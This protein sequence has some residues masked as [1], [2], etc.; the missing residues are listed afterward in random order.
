MSMSIKLKKNKVIIIA[1]VVVCCLVLMYFCYLKISDRQIKSILGI[2]Y[3]SVNNENVKFKVAYKCTYKYNGYT[4]NKCF[5]QIIYYICSNKNDCTKKL[6]F[7]MVP[8][9][10]NEYY[11]DEKKHDIGFKFVN[12]KLIF[13]YKNSYFSVDKLI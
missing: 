7:L 4:E 13:R 6:A 9:L 5:I 2:Y 1:V 3:G 10:F 11:W 12:N 8:N